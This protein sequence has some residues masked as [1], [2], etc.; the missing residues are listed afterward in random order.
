M[1]RIVKKEKLNPVVYRMEVEAPRVAESALPGQF[2][3]VRTEE[4]GE[5]VPLTISDYDPEKGTVTI[6]IQEIGASTED[7]CAFEEGQAFADVVGPLGMPSDF[8]EMSD[9][10]LKGRQYVFIAGGVGTA[11]VYPQV[12]VPLLRQSVYLYR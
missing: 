9:E 2:L 12:N 4:K 3:I 1:F 8:T 10:A 5:R 6:V 11:P 7:I